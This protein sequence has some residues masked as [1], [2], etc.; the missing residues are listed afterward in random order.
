M[1]DRE[2]QRERERERERESERALRP[3]RRGSGLADILYLCASGAGVTR[4]R[5]LSLQI[6]ISRTDRTRAHVGTSS[7]GPSGPEEEE[8]KEERECCRV[9]QL[10]TGKG[11]EHIA[12]DNS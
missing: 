11:R 8:E 2:L 6:S 1:R 3:D 10:G 4:G 12:K 9:G 5:P 7:G